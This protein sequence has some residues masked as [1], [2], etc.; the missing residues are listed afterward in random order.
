MIAGIT[1]Q[2]RQRPKLCGKLS[3][4]ALLQ[5]AAA[6]ECP[7]Q[8]WRIRRALS[9]ACADV[10]ANE[11]SLRR[12]AVGSRRGG[13]QQEREQGEG[14]CWM[15][16]MQLSVE[17]SAG[18]SSSSPRST[19][20]SPSTSLSPSLRRQTAPVRHMLK[21][22]VAPVRAGANVGNNGRP[23]T[24]HP[25]MRSRDRTHAPF[26]EGHILVAEHPTCVTQHTPPSL[27]HAAHEM[28]HT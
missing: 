13:Q 20:P 10:G 1:E 7:R 24:G 26:V 14:R 22:D 16:T 9:L 12:G 3:L 28:H 27:Q 18:P 23:A 8:A 17:A 11:R 21:A 15:G 5:A 6:R 4:A 25:R 2:R 19:S